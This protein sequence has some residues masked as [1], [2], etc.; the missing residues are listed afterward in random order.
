M[1]RAKLEDSDRIFWIPMRITLKT[2][3][4]TLM[5]VTPDT[6]IAWHRKGWRYYWDRKSKQGKTGSPGDQ[7]GDN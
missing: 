3:R 4:D 1:E 5:I 2:W 7:P 6:V